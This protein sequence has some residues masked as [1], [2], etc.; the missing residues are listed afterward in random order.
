[1]SHLDMMF[2]AAGGGRCF[3]VGADGGGRG[4]GW[5]CGAGGHGET[6]TARVVSG[7]GLLAPA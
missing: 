6:R 5:R 3:C 7:G 2:G 4:G 1:M